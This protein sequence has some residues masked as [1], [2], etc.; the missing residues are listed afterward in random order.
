MSL[1]GGVSISVHKATTLPLSLARDS[2]NNKVIHERKTIQSLIDGSKKPP[3]SRIDTILTNFFPE[4]YGEGYYGMEIGDVSCRPTFL[5][6]LLHGLIY[7]PEVLNVSHGHLHCDEIYLN[8]EGEIKIGDV[9]KSMIQTGKTK[10]VSRGVQAVC[11]IADQL[12]SLDSNSD[13]TCM[14]WIIAKNFVTMPSTVDPRTLL[15]HPFLKF[16]QDSWY[17][18]SLSGLLS[19]VRTTG[20]VGCSKSSQ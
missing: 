11:K 17:L 7:I 3:Y 10:D 1:H 12:L 8:D 15:K 13:T 20:L 18:S 2:D 16:S 9:G 14:S 4:K 5:Q 6:K 19:F